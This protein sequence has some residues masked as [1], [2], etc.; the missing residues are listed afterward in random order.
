MF[1]QVPQSRRYGPLD[2]VLSFGLDV[3]LLMSPGMSNWHRDLV[4][5]EWL[6]GCG[7][8]WKQLIPMAFLLARSRTAM[9]LLILHLGWNDLPHASVPDLKECIL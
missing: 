7:M 1:Y 6:G 2:I 3:G 9:E 8:L 4:V 5:V